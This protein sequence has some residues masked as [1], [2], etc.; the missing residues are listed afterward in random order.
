MPGSSNTPRREEGARRGLLRPRARRDQA[1]HDAK[2][3][4]ATKRVLG[5]L[6]ATAGVVGGTLVAGGVPGT[7]TFGWPID[8]VAPGAG[9]IAA[10]IAGLVTLNGVQSWQDKQA[11]H[12]ATAT[13]ENRARAYE[14]VLAHII[15][16]FTP[17]GSPMDREALVRGMAASWA[18]VDT[19]QALADWF[20]FAGTHSGHSGPPKEHSF[21]VVW[22]VIRAMRADIDPTSQVPKDSVLAMIFNDYDPVGHNPPGIEHLT[23]EESGRVTLP[24]KT[25]N[26]GDPSAPESPG[27]QP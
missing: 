8:V 26:D 23:V 2:T 20:R 15:K 22:R 18:S 17:G 4:S 24:P 3:V 16:S 9:L 11:E 14:Q 25:P 12:I 1:G 10:A 7:G 21:E 13:R 19:S 27:I 5:G 6:C